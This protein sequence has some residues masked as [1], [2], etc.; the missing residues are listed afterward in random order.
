M[1]LGVG[2]DHHR[3]EV[4]EIFVGP[5]VLGELDRGAQQLAVILLELLFEPLEQGEG[6]GRRAGEAA[7][8]LAPPR[9]SAGP[10]SHWA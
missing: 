5:P 1:L 8:H 3:F 6:V 9:R 2:D 4:A 7:D 10:S